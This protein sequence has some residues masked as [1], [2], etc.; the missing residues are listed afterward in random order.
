MAFV[1]Y[2]FL[3][4]DPWRGYDLFIYIFPMKMC[5]IWHDPPKTDAFFQNERVITKVSIFSLQKRSF[6]V[7][8]NR[9][10]LKG[11]RLLKPAEDSVQ[12][13]EQQIAEMKV[14][15]CGIFSVDSP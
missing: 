5:Q 7:G 4:I 6:A 11:R 15:E 13:L 12:R 2:D 1:L 10:K 3:D 9:L 8:W 14:V